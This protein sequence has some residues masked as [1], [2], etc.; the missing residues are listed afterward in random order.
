MNARI[1][2]RYRFIG[3]LVMDTALHIGGRSDMP[4]TDSSIIRDMEGRPFIPG[5]SFKGAFRATV[6][7]IAGNFEQLRCCVLYDGE[8]I[9]CLSQKQNSALQ[10]EYKQLTKQRNELKMAEYLEQNL[11]DACKLFG[12]PYSAGKIFFYDQPVKEPW[13]MVTEI[14]DGVGLDRD[15]DKAVHGIKFDFEAVPAGTKFRF[16][17]MAENVNSKELGIIAIGLSEFMNGMVS[18]GGVRTRGLGRCH[19]ELETIEKVQMNNPESLVNYLKTR[20]MESIANPEVFI[21]ER[22]SGLLEGR[23]V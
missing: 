13:G 21:Q 11:C 23:A 3:T 17:M 8:N 2:N 4:L 22:L 7:R 10:K 5:S 6:E 20:R 16:E 14:R 15:S 12:S 9:G 1:E 18:M 19:L